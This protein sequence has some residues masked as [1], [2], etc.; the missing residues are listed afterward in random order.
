MEV[1]ISEIQIGQNALREV[2]QGEDFEDL[3]ASVRRLGVVQPVIVRRDGEGFVLVAGH[4]RVR[5]AIEVGL[6]EIPAVVAGGNEKRDSEVAFAENL[7]RKDMSAVETATAL[8]DVLAEGQMQIEQLARGVHRSVHWV[9]Q[10]VAMCDWPSEVL[11]AIHQGSISV[12]AGSNLALVTEDTYRQYLVNNAVDNGATARI[13]AAW[14]QAFR[15]MQPPEEAVFTEP[16][17]GVQK[18]LPLIPQ[19]PCLC[20]GHVFRMDALSHVPIC[21]GCVQILRT[22]GGVGGQEG[23]VSP[24]LLDGR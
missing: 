10:M 6:E 14:L 18:P 5:A 16:V 9:Q 19:A 15:S 7:F 3:I 21:V 11:L 23:V 17:D 13:T 2:D 4:R 20:C 1:K 8:K 24:G 22:A 12:A